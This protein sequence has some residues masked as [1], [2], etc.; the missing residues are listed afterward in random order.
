MQEV[1]AYV[2][3]FM[4]TFDKMQ[5]TNP[6]MCTEFE[7]WGQSI[8]EDIQAVR[9]VLYIGCTGPVVECLY[10]TVNDPTTG[11]EHTHTRTHAHTHYY[12]FFSGL[13]DEAIVAPITTV[14]SKLRLGLR[15]G[16]EVI[17]LFSCSTQL[18]TKFQLLIKTKIPTNKEVSCF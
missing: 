4:L 15:S 11:P 8:L 12:K 13:K 2:L 16:T 9:I 18:S 3:Q 6:L 1:F 17:K 5:N 14:K 7:I 10:E